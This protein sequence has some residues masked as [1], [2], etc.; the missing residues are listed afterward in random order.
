MAKDRVA[1]LLRIGEVARRTGMSTA[2]LRAWE[3]RYDMF[4]PRRTP[5][6]QRLYSEHD[7]ERV[8]EVQRWVAQGWSVAA[9]TRRLRHEPDSPATPAAQR[10]LDALAPADPVAV[11]AAYETLRE[12]L[13]ADDVAHLRDCL[14]ALV[15]RLGGTVGPAT[16]QRDDLI[17]TDISFGAGPPLLPSAEPG[18]LARMRIELVLPL[19][20]EDARVIAHRLRL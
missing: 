4:S 13:R 6:G 10:L 12:L 7:V 8:R 5:G 2:T 16:S 20:V 1:T 15:R 11:L 9:A 14:R 3:R 18:S 19:L 17:P